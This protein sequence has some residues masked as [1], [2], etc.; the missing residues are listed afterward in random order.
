MHGIGIAGAAMST[1]FEYVDPHYCKPAFVNELDL[2]EE[3]SIESPKDQDVLVLWYDEAIVIP[4]SRE[5]ILEFVNRI[6]TAVNTS[7]GEDGRAKRPDPSCVHCGRDIRDTSAA[8]PNVPWVHV[9]T[10]N[11]YCDV[12]GPFSAVRNAGSSE[13]L[14]AE[15]EEGWLDEYDEDRECARCGDTV[16]T[17]SSD[18]LCD[19]CV[20]EDS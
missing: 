8:D 17:L 19:G 9:T 14:Q 6:I 12:D 3:N 10:V 15:P 7:V 4:G 5:E 13:R 18:N 11:A 1:R 2:A 16:S 20:E